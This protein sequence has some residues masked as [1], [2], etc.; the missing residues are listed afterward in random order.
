MTYEQWRISYQSSEQAA[1]AAYAE[2]E[3][4]ENIVLRTAELEAM[5]PD[6]CQLIDAVKMEWSQQGCWS[7]WDQSVRDGITEYNLKRLGEACKYLVEPGKLCVKCGG[8]HTR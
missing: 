4:L 7:E 3:R 8:I 6:I 1:R 2:V 5:L